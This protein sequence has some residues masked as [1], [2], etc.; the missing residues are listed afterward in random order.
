MEGE[1]IS[2]GSTD[3]NNA[4][5]GRIVGMNG[6]MNDRTIGKIGGDGDRADSD[7]LPIWV[8]LLETAA[9]L[10]CGQQKKLE[11][12]RKVE[13]DIKQSAANVAACKREFRQSYHDGIG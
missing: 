1:L 10:F 2:L 7:R 5:S 4:K 3:R 12:M 6:A 9:W 13:Q 8:G 11:R